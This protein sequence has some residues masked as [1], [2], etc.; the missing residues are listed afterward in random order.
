MK[1]FILS[2]SLITLAACAEKPVAQNSLAADTTPREVASPA[3]P[4]T[5]V[6]EN[7]AMALGKKYGD[8]VFV[9]NVSFKESFQEPVPGYMTRE[10][11]TW[12][13]SFT[14]SRGTRVGRPGM[15]A[16]F[17]KNQ[18][19][20]IGLIRFPMYAPQSSGASGEA[21]GPSR[22][23]N[24]CKKMGGSLLKQVGSCSL[25]VS[26]SSTAFSTPYY[27][28]L[29]GGVSQDGEF[30]PKDQDRALS[31]INSLQKKGLCQ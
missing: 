4:Y 2:L 6:C 27:E 1:I 3:A 14:D 29:A 5:P 28:V 11:E 22:S 9:P 10:F 24:P 23:A 8:K 19:C 7:S 25:C 20:Q 18:Q 26:K 17:Y 31:Y 15:E 12:T 21:T 16:T 13:I 30:D